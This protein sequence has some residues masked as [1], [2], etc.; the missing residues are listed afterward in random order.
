[1]KTRKYKNTKNA[2]EFVGDRPFSEC[3]AGIRRNSD[4]SQRLQYCRFFGILLTVPANDCPHSGD[5]KGLE[6]HDLSPD[7][8]TE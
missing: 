3:F 2:P 7:V 8:V 1:M 4:E 5:T 6:N